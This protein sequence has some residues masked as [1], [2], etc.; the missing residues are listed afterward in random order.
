MTVTYRLLELIAMLRALVQAAVAE[1]GTVPDE[2]SHA[3]VM[4]EYGPPGTL[5]VEAVPIPVPGPGQVRLAVRAAGVGPTDLKIRRGD[6]Q[7]VF[8]L[9][10][11]PVLGFEAAGVVDAVGQ[12][13]VGTSV[14]DE[15]VALLAALGGYAEHVLASVWAPKPSEVSW[16]DAA[17]LPASAEAAVGV[18]RQLHVRAG[19]TL[20]VLGAAGSVGLLAV[21]LARAQNVK[22]LAAARS[23]QHPLLHDLGA[24]PV[25]LGPHLRQQARAHVRHVDAV[26]DAAGAGLEDAIELAGAPDRVI[27]LAD[28]RGAAALHATMSGPTPERAPDAL[29]VTLPLLASG[30]LR[31]RPR[32]SYPLVRA[33][34]AHQALEDRSTGDKL[35]LT[36]G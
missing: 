31:L 16:V 8:A 23:E 32:R 1:G 10:D 3:I 9:P 6:L 4:R 14:G 5:R 21:Q 17:A 13:V 26:L 33:A 36:L 11:P 35:V 12:G 22:V 19:E 34:E 27:T 15:V 29:S 24:V 2:V 28:P 7:G 18:L 25:E 20:L 30:R